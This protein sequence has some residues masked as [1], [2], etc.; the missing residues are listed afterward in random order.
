[1]RRSEK[2]EDG[3][4]TPPRPTCVNT[5]VRR[6]V[7]V[8]AS[9]TKLTGQSGRL[10]TGWLR[11]RVPLFPLGQDMLSFPSFRRHGAIGSTPPRHGG[12]CGFKSRCLL[13]TPWSKQEISP[14]C[15]GGDCGFEPRRSRSCG[16]SAA[17]R[18]SALQAE[19]REFN[20]LIP[21]LFPKGIFR[22]HGVTVKHP[23]LPSRRC[24][25]DSGCGLPLRRIDASRPTTR[26][27]YGPAR[28]H[29]SLRLSFSGG[30]GLWGCTGWP[31]AL[32]A[33]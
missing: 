14:P 6:T 26:E 10:L 7:R 1:M 19:C 3:G 15:H 2:P 16:I 4:S 5:A 28:S 32:Q 11:V 30:Y 31:P 13:T 24:R 22:P 12:D 9:G 18:A 21:H 17:G 27:R 29:G 23:C 8:S 33:G 20:P 25:F